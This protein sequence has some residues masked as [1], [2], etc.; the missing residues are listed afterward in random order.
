MKPTIA[1]AEKSPSLAIIKL[2][3]REQGGHLLHTDSRFISAW[4]E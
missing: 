1:T 2:K 3:G 4:M